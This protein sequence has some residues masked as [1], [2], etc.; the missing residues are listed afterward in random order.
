MQDR[1][2]GVTY[3]GP[4]ATTDAAGRASLLWGGWRNPFEDPP[5]TLFVVAWCAGFAEG[6]SGWVCKKPFVGGEIEKR[7]KGNELL[8]PL[9]ERSPAPRGVVDRAFVGRR[10]RVDVVDHVQGAGGI[11]YILQRSYEVVIAADGTYDVPQ[12]PI[13]ASTVRLQLPPHEGRRVDLLAT[14]APALPNASLAN[15]DVV[16]GEVL[17]EGGGPA[18]SA[19]V[20]LACHPVGMTMQPVVLDAAGRFDRLV[21]RGRWTLLAKNETGWA[22]RELDGEVAG[23]IELRLEAMPQR[24]VRVLAADGSPVVGASFEPGEFPFG[25]PAQTGLRALLLEELGWN[26]FAAQ[27]RRARTDERGE[28]TLHFLPWPGVSPSAFAF[29]G[30]HRRRSDDVGIEPGG[31]VLVFTLR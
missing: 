12:L 24:R 6:S 3:E 22:A 15:I 16:K 7:H 29:V 2:T 20:L 26:A 31:N 9:T 23:P 4:A 13:G 14:H 1:S 28:A 27:V 18:T 19:Q 25:F 30:D 10:A 21:Q 5:H 8:V 11:S 17:D